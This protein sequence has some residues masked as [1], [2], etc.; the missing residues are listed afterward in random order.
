MTGEDTIL[1][2]LA[3]EEALDQLGRKVEARGSSV[4]AYT[5]NAIAVF[6][7]CLMAGPALDAD[8][9]TM[10]AWVGDSTL[11]LAL[12]RGQ[13]LLFARNV[14]GGLAILDAAIAQTFNV[15]DER[16]RR[17]RNELLDLDPASRGRYGSTQEEKVAHAVQGV[18]GQ[19][20]A[21]LRSTVAFCQ[22]QTNIQDLQLGRIL[23]CGPGAK[24]RGMAAFLGSGLR[25]PV[26]VWDPVG[27]LDLSALDATQAGAL[28]KDGPECV[29][30]LGLAMG[31]CYDELYSIEVLPESVAKKRR[32]LQRTVWNVAAAV[33]AVAWLGWSFQHSSTE[34]ERLESKAST[35][36]TQASRAK[37]ID[38]EC[39]K[40]IEENQVMEQRI[41]KLEELAVPHHGSAR[42][43]RAL[44]ATLPEEFWLKKF[45]TTV[46]APPDPSQQ[47]KGTGNTRFRKGMT[48]P[49][50][51]FEGLG[52]PILGRDIQ[53]EVY[54]TFKAAFDQYVPFHAPQPQQGTPF[55]FR[56]TVDFL[57][58]DMT[59]PA[60]KDED[61]DKDKPK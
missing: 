52:L 1:L 22:A 51:V 44:R 42:L 61:E 35:L 59:K 5:P 41:A 47:P 40:L 9:T 12:V 56:E 2:A 36:K 19:L 38:S 13:T 46:G 17:I 26:D 28:T 30:A 8:E 53:R 3:K 31:P 14:S 11:D 32:F 55:R 7:A 16:A 34:Y 60:P 58:V 48:R 39:S 10:L 24:V 23:L 57:W 37:S 54:P 18:S 25:C 4:A 20:Q 27:N 6:N 33:L 29:V 21:A 49:L 50:L 45:E 15:R 43:M